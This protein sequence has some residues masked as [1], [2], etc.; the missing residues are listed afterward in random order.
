VIFVLLIGLLVVGQTSVSESAELQ[1][2]ASKPGAKVTVEREIDDGKVLVSVSDAA[3]N[4]LFGLTASDFVITAEA[5][6][7][8]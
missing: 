5:G 2:N 7:P 3:R 4:P 8:G 6:P 1:V